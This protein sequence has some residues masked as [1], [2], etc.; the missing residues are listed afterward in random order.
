M[1][2]WL[3]GD[4]QGCRKPLRKLLKIIDPV[5]GR[6]Q[7]WFLGDLVNR[8][9]DSFSTL[10]QVVELGDMANSVLGNHDLHLLAEAHTAPRQHSDNPEFRRLLAHRHADRLIDWLLQRPM[11]HYLESHDT[12]LVHA[13]VLPAWS[14]KQTLKYAGEV[15][16]VLRGDE[17]G[18]FFERMYG[19]RPRRWKADLKGWPRLR[20]ITNTL[21]RLRYC[22]L[23]GR[24]AYK[25]KGPPGS[26][27][28][29]T[30]PWFAYP[31][32]R[33]RNTTIAFGHWSALGLMVSD[34]LIALDTGAVWGGQ[35]SAICL[36][37]REI[38]QV[39]GLK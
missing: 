16:N 7:L 15:E 26:Q 13:G 38:V 12:L 28:R 14:L 35:L 21:T 4:L 27:S 36:D 11:A 32:R 30:L 18:Q 29:G 33:L 17:P 2:T 3:I 20:L 8:G 1:A 25:D 34:K 6:D 37:D 9:G 24:I 22:D 10:K 31:K 23:E 19:N 39:S 5:A